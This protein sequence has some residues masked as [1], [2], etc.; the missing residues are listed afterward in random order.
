[1]KPQVTGALILLAGAGMAGGIVMWKRPKPHVIVI[2]APATPEERLAAAAA[3]D[4]TPDSAVPPSSRPT[5]AKPASTPAPPVPSAPDS[6][7]GRD[8]A[9]VSAAETADSAISPAAAKAVGRILVNMKPVEAVRILSQLTDEQLEAIIRGLQPK[10][11]AAL[12]AKLPAERAAALSRRL[13]L[14]DEGVR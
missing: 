12:M 1:M 8:G 13:L 9:P 7:A 2:P 6:S 4:V 10:Q 11:T 14:V 3:T 5:P